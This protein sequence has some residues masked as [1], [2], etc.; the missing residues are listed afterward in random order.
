M[1]GAIPGLSADHAT[2]GGGGGPKQHPVF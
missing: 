2:L 1:Q